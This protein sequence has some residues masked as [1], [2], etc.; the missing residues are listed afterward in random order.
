MTKQPSATVGADVVNSILRRLEML[1]SMAHGYAFVGIMSMVLGFVVRGADDPASLFEAFPTPG[2][3]IL[4]GVFFTA[5]SLLCYGVSAT[6][7]R[8]SRAERVDRRAVT[9][10]GGAQKTGT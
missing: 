10:A 3:A 5:L 2:F 7:A 6:R 1:L 9:E 4:L 8:A